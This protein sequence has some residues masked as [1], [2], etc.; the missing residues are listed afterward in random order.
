MNMINKNNV[1]PEFRSVVLMTLGYN[2]VQVFSRERQG[3]LFADVLWPGTVNG[4]VQIYSKAS[5]KDPGS[6][7]LSFSVTD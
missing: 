5:S 7:K 2:F 1:L 4:N 6:G 3:K